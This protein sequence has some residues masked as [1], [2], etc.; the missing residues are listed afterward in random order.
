MNLYLYLIFLFSSILV[1][2]CDD[3]E[4]FLTKTAPINVN[5]QYY[6]NKRNFSLLAFSKLEKM[7]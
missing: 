2:Y 6:L 1:T 7:L 4:C 3:T 5:N